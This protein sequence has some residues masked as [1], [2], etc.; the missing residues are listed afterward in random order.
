MSVQVNPCNACLKKFQSSGD[1]DYNSVKDCCYDTVAAFEGVDSNQIL[2][3]VQ[4]CIQCTK[5]QMPCLPGLDRGPC[6]T[7]LVMPPIWNQIPHYF[8][9]LLSKLHDPKA[10]LQQCMQ[11][12][13]DDPL[14]VNECREACQTDYSAVEKYTSSNPST[15]NTNK[16]S[17]VIIWIVGIIMLLLIVGLLVRF[18]RVTKYKR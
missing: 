13:K 10:A 15:Q 3:K 9:V 14:H 6:N 16:D 18:V 7:S 2:D 17:K 11:N 5:N 4:N 8:P 1:C 12:C